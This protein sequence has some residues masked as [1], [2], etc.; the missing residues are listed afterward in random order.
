MDFIKMMLDPDLSVREHFWELWMQLTPQERN[1]YDRIALR[2]SVE[3]ETEEDR[4]TAESLW[5][6]AKERFNGVG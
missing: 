2:A 4:K 3:A 5:H 1:T 6:L